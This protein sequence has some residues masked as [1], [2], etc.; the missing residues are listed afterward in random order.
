MTT[1]S[2]V[3]ETLDLIFYRNVSKVYKVVPKR[4]LD[5]ISLA[6]ATARMRV[7]ATE[8][9]EAILHDFA[10]VVDEVENT[11]TFGLRTADWSGV[12]WDKGVY[13]LKIIYET[14][15][16]VPLFRGSISIKKDVP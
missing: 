9:S 2:N 7:R 5:V 4:G 15:D 3:P 6:G 1:L 12:A 8:D 10:P 14:G 11:I 13:D 16:A